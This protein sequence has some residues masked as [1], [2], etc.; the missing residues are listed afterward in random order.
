MTSP[1]D[2]C[3]IWN[4][5]AATVEKY[6]VSGYFDQRTN[7]WHVEHSPR[8]AGSF[9]LPSVL[10]NS[11]LIRMSDEQKARLT[12]WLIDQRNQGNEQPLITKD[13]IDYVKTK[14]PLPVHERADR[15]LRYL[16]NS[17][18]ITGELVTLGTL[19]NT[20]DSYGHRG[21]SE[22]STFWEA[23][24][25]SESIKDNEVEFFLD[26]LLEKGWIKGRREGLGM[27]H[28]IVTI[29][30]YSHIADVSVNRNLSQVFVAMW[31]DNSM[32]ESYQTGIEQAV[33]DAGYKPFR[34]DQKEHINKIDD[35]IIAEIRRSRFLVADF[36]QGDDGARGGVYYEAGFAHGLG[37]PVIFTCREDAVDKLHFDTNH[38]NHI[39]WATPEELREKL[40]NRILAV[41]GEG[42]GIGNNP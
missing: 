26:Y 36:T 23:M 2:L 42:P 24:A 13:I 27:G 11:E 8:A 34:I 19:S 38:Y 15:F 3:P 30:G 20:A 14:L 17:T 31:F 1:L 6:Q 25:W 7:V 32:N 37:I 10:C 18:D 35:E 12:T 4:S 28:F 41:I 22:G 33:W 9:V 39:V 40:N 29:D 21:F 16:V 5:D